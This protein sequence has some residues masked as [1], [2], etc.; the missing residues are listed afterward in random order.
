MPAAELDCIE[1]DW[2]GA[3]L[4]DAALDGAELLL[5]ATE[6]VIDAAILL[7]VWLELDDDEAT[8][9]EAVLLDVLS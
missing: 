4:D 9:D 8:T 5:T 1:L 6:L 3:A 7:A 2:A